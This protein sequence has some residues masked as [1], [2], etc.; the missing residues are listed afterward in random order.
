MSLKLKIKKIFQDKKKLKIIGIGLL[1]AGAAL[2]FFIGFRGRNRGEQEPSP[3][4]SPTISPSPSP[5]E[6][7]E[8]SIP[9]QPTF[10][11]KPSPTKKIIKASGE[12]VI[13][14]HTINY[15]V[16]FPA[17]GGTISGEGSGICNGTGTGTFEGDNST[18]VSGTLTGNCDYYGTSL[19]A[20][21]NFSG[22]IYVKDGRAEGTWEGSANGHSK[23]GA[24]SFTF[25]PIN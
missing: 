15:S 21:G 10:K 22:D 25:P 3:S 16:S 7:P 4:P 24:W 13:E 11:P 18:V 6:Y 12:L 9:P 8:I 1:Y 20:A 17:K 14:S 23:S 19:S 2:A 5:S